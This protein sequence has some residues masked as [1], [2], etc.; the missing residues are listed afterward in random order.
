[1]FR[2]LSVICAVVL[3]S[4]ALGGCDSGTYSAEKRFWNASKDLN[5]LLKAP[6]KASPVDYQKIIDKFREITIR[7]PMWPNSSQAQFNIGQLYAMQGSLAKSREE[8]L[9]IPKDYPDNKDLSSRALYMVALTYESADDWSNALET[10]NK[11]TSGYPDTGTA[12]QVPVHIAEYL[13]LKGRN[14]EASA[15]YV[16]ALDK[17]KKYITDDPKTYG[18]LVA[19]D[20]IVTCYAD[21][22]KWDEALDYLNSLIAAHEDKL[23]APKALFVAGAIYEQKTNQPDKAIQ[24]Y[25]RILE[26]YSNTPFAKLAGNQLEALSKSK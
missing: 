18:A 19:I 14:D 1:M 20:L 6:D 25:R 7:Y 5:A 23:V 16:A 22:G 9:A 26:K 3:V 17:Y 8:F 12:L 15:A 11:I 24:N 2:K 10:L 21:Q 13:K 4:A